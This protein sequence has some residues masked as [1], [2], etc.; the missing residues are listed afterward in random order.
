MPRVK[1]NTI[2]SFKIEGRTYS[3][4]HNA[5]RAFADSLA[6]HLDHQRDTK[7]RSLLGDDDAAWDRYYDKVDEE[8]ERMFFDRTWEKA[9]RRCLPIFQRYFQ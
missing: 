6:W 4:A 8:D 1:R 7:L 9:Y 3:T 5:A 2:K